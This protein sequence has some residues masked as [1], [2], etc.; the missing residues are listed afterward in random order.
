MTKIR[1]AEAAERSGLTV[2]ALRKEVARGRL[3]IFRVANKDYTSLEEI[4][5]MFEQCQIQPKEPASGYG[6]QLR[7]NLAKSFNTL[8][9]LSSIECDTLALDALQMRVKRLKNSSPRI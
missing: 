9:G 7:G 2:S 1:L 4:E 5:R 3:K 6:Q 8:A